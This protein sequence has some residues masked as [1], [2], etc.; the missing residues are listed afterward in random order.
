ML[1][2]T[3]F[4]LI[5][6]AIASLFLAVV[7]TLIMHG[8]QSFIDNYLFYFLFFALSSGAGIALMTKRNLSALKGGLY[9]TL[10]AV[11]GIVILIMTNL[12]QLADLKI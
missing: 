7:A 12:A 5:T 10:L 1:P 9:G 2:K 11:M 6:Y 4:A 3:K 8:S